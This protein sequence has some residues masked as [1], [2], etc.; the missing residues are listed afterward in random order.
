GRARAGIVRPG[1]GEAYV[2]GIF[3]LPERLGGKLA[4]HLGSGVAG[5]AADASEIVLAR[6]VG[7]DGRTRAYLNGRT[8][9]V[10]DLRDI[11]A[12]L[13]AFYGQHDHRKLT[14]SAAQL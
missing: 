2:E 6:R 14:L 5:G 10:G 12:T 8:V 11:G 9:A 7:A 1:A 4:E 13:L 3:D